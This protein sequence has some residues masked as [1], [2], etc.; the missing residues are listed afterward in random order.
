MNQQVI[1]EHL[2]RVGLHTVV[3]GNGKIGLDLVK[4][5]LESGE[6]QFDLIF[7]DMHMPVMDGFEAAAELLKLKTGIPIVAMTANVMSRDKELY[8]EH[9]M[10]GYVGKPFT[11]QELWRCLMNH[12]PVKGYAGINKRA[13]NAEEEKMLQKLKADFVKTNQDTTANIVKAVNDGDIKLAHR[14]A[15]TLKGYARQ[16][17]EIALAELAVVVENR[18]TNEKRLLDDEMRSLNNEMKS[19]LERLALLSAD[20]SIMMVSEQR[21]EP[22]SQEELTE[23]LEKLEPMLKEKDTASLQFLPSLRTAPAAQ[24]LADQ[25]EDYNFKQALGTLQTLREELS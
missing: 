25:I 13:Q 4:S 18:L 2:S 17:D 10:S 9:G 11:S 8:E 6:K 20:I 14:L 22:V 16:I 7:M 15:H 24:E 21:S 23:L 1:S 5:R 3:A 12:I 19:V